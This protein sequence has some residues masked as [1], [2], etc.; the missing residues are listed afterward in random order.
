MRT[1][2]RHA[3]LS[4]FL[5]SASLA[6][7][8]LMLAA[9]AQAAAVFDAGGLRI[10]AAQQS[11]R[12][13]NTGQSQTF[14]IT[15]A[16]FQGEALC[17]AGGTLGRYLH[18]DDARLATRPY[19]CLSPVLPVG[20]D[21]VLMFFR[22]SNETFL[23][24]LTARGGRLRVERLWLSEDEARD[25]VETRKLLDARMP[26]WSRVQTDW[27][28]T[29]LIHHESLRVVRLGAGMLLDI[30][31]DT[32]FLMTPPGETVVRQEP[33]RLVTGPGGASYVE[34]G[35]VITRKTPLMFR[36]VR[37]RDGAE[38]ARLE[39]KDAC[40][41]APGLDLDGRPSSGKDAQVAYADV[42]AW[43]ARTLSYVPG[44]NARL[45]L[46]PGAELPRAPGCAAR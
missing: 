33:N 13:V 11:Q 24:G 27:T 29:A 12:D 10:D 3:R 22:D 28:E 7:A 8:P 42:P 34:Q 4:R 40:L 43:R 1:L 15:A 25:T 45:L 38:L 20:P 19:Y 21:S 32:A 46:A 37:W 6:A 26:G 41:Q 23:A 35:K 39:V 5:R 17:G 44:R 18:P 14:R 31:G 16:S 2:L 30:D 36:A 9:T